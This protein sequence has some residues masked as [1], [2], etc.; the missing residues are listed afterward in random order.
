M[1]DKYVK[2]R[3]VIKLI[4]DFPIDLYSAEETKKVL[5]EKVNELNPADVIVPVNAVCMKDIEWDTD[6]DEVDGLPEAEI[7]PISSLLYDDED[8]D[9]IDVE[10]LL[11]RA[12]D[13]L[14]DEHGFCIFGCDGELVNVPEL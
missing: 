14:S 10:E 3:D 1:E 7:I 12:V 9:D 11:D 13:Y 8:G 5:L 4:D 6:G 2:L